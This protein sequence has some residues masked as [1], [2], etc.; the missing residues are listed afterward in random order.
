MIKIEEYMLRSKEDRQMHIK[1][2]EQCIERGGP[3]KGG[4][5]AYCKGL[6]AHILD[7]SIP[8]GKFIYVCH[9]CNN[10]KCSNPHHLYW[11]TPKEN[12]DDKMK[13]GCK[14]AWEFTVEKYGL[15]EAKRIVKE[16]SKL[17]AAKGGS[18]GKGKGKKRQKALNENNS[19]CCPICNTKKYIKYKFCS[20]KCKAKAQEKL[21]W[22]SLN[23]EDQLKHKS[24]TALGKE[25][26]VSDNAIRKYLKRK[27]K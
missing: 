6:L 26:G 2:E 21:N 13:A 19:N 18:A 4:L 12:C 1:L 24:M 7:T 17:G 10:E 5:S 9:A 15:E 3:E 20:N 8:S 27:N 23:I 25:L 16:N 22:D 11:G 14:T